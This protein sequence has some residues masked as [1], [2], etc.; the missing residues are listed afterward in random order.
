MLATTGPYC[1][2]I[3][4]ADDSARKA[5]SIAQ[6]RLTFYLLVCSLNGEEQIVVDG[7]PH[8][9][10]PRGCYL[11]PP[12]VL[13]D[14]GSKRGSRPGWIH[15]DAVWNP[16]RAKSPHVGPYSSDLSARRQYLQPPPLEIWGV[17]LPVLVP[18]PLQ[19]L[20]SEAIPRIIG[21]VKRGDRLAYLEATTTLSS[22]MLTWVAYEWKRASPAGGFD[23]ES[24]VARAELLARQ[25]L[26]AGFSVADFARAA[27]L[28]RSQFSLLYSR[29]R[30]ISP[31]IF[32]RQERLRQAEALLLRS[33]L[34]LSEIGALVGY[35][36]PSVFGRVFRSAHGLSPRS[37]RRKTESRQ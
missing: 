35:P 13:S 18:E 26:G 29:L 21:L 33:D 11:V 20:F 19:S 34:P 2:Y 8:R 27:N 7:I 1:I 24:R 5:W 32:L 9:V 16:E 23:A 3:H 28:S 36:D 31:G 15:F 37:W 4:A 30:G 22:L 10:P 14:L 6:R 25:N 17:S 12:E